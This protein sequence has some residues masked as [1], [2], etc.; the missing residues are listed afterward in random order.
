MMSKI[1]L[2]YDERSLISP[3]GYC[4][5]PHLDKSISWFGKEIYKVTLGL[6][7]HEDGVSEFYKTIDEFHKL[8]SSQINMRV[9]NS[10]VYR[11]LRG[12]PYVGFKIRDKG[13][14]AVPCWN[15]NGERTEPPISGDRIQVRFSLAGWN[16][17]TTAGIKVYLDSVCVIDRTGIP[18][19]EKQIKEHDCDD[20]EW[21]EW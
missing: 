15:T 18:E 10:I 6:D 5:S 9:T 14:G 2:T 1:N 8:Y 21:N 11:S 3:I 4:W 16:N 7:D 19:I 13:Q 12:N 17:G 20:G